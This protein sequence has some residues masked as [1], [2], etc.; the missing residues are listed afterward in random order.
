MNQTRTRQ[1]L[2][3]VQS[4]IK[5]LQG[6]ETA[7]VIDWT[8]LT[9]AIDGLG[10]HLALGPEPE[11]RACP[12]CGKLGRRNATVCGYCWAKTPPSPKD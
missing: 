3:D 10:D 7:P 9:G 5:H 1:L 2:Q 8:I 4:E 6:V 12:V 11:T